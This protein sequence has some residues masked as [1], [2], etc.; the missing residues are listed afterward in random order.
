MPALRRRATGRGPRNWRRR[1][2]AKKGR[3]VRRKAMY[4]SQ[5]F[6]ETFKANATSSGITSDGQIQVPMPAQSIGGKLMVKITDV[7]QVQQYSALYNF[8]KIL[9]VQAIVIPKWSNAD[10]NVAG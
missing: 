5:V 6:T 9:K 10:P 3:A 8:Y 4:Q 1:A 7:P 2:A